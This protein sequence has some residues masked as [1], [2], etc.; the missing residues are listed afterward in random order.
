LETTTSAVPPE[1]LAVN[2]HSLGIS[3]DWKHREYDRAREIKV[4]EEGCT[5]LSTMGIPT[6]WG[7]QLI[8]N[9][10]ELGNLEIC[11]LYSHSLGIS[12]DWKPG[13][14]SIIGKTISFIP[15]RWGS[16]LIGNIRSN[17]ED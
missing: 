17:F 14:F 8:G 16:Q 4:L 6:R 7:S 2:S 11:I 1:S 3:T 15:T 12:T 13:V 9:S 10:S 5:L